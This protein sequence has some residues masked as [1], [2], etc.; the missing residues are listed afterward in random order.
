MLD[1]GRTRSVSKKRSVSEGRD[2]VGLGKDREARVREGK[3][4][5]K[6]DKQEAMCG[7]SN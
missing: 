6:G 7:S 3:V 1:S 4:R 2:G 5:C